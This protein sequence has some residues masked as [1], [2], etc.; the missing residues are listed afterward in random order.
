[1]TDPTLTRAGV[2]VELKQWTEVGHSN[3]PDSATDDYGG[4]IVHPS[5]Q[6]GR[7]ETGGGRDA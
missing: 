2:I 7:M 6:L 3:I 1:M 5:R 4:N